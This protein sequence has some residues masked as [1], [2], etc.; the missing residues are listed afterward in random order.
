MIKA[1]YIIILLLLLLLGW[2]VA[3]MLRLEER[4]RESRIVEV[5]LEDTK[6]PLIEEFPLEQIS[7]LVDSSTCWFKAEG[8]YFKVFANR[9]SARGERSEQWEEV[10]LKG[11]NMGVALPGK[12]PSEFAA[13]YD[14]YLE[15]FIMIG[16]MNANTIRTYTILPP[17]FYKALAWHNL[18]YEN[19]K[20]WLMQG[21][22][23]EEPPKKT[24]P[25]AVLLELS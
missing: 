7:A 2:V 16:N 17:E 9:L 13:T 20:L 21:V 8:D 23:A 24:M 10:F 25:M 15:W 12:W 4:I 6:A 22:W 14:Q 3:Q 11:V 18:H 5:V 19:K 1:K